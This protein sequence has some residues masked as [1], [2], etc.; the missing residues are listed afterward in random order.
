MHIG[1][2]DSS[3]SELQ[4]NT[5][6]DVDP[7]KH[8]SEPPRGSED[9]DGDV[10]DIK[11]DPMRLLKELEKENARLSRRNME[12]QAQ[13]AFH[14]RGTTPHEQDPEPDMKEYQECLE[15]LVELRRQRVSQMEK[16]QRQEEELRLINQE[17]L[18]RVEDEWQYLLTWK[19]KVAVS[20]LRGHLSPEAARAKVDA[21][22]GSEQRHR[23]ELRKLRLVHAGMESR[24]IRLEAELGEEEQEEGRD[25][26]LR[27]LKQLVAQRTLERKAN[28]RRSQEASKIRKN[29]KRTL[30]L[31]S[32][33]K[34]KLHWSHTE[35][36]AKREQLTRLEAT[37]TSR[38]DLLTR[39]KRAGGSLR[40]DNAELKRTRGLLGNTLLLWDFGVTVGASQRLQDKLEEL[41]GRREEIASL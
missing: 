40:R 21:A 15:H 27:Q 11:N 13:M 28:E 14:M 41:K 1:T 22:L 30:E 8:E 37:L 26:L 24:V 38:R 35:A 3:E 36:Q 18:N 29:I 34:E 16:A 20:L 5:E 6:G 31:L 7:L 12:L 4:E 9:L 33:I 25:L 23:Q 2:E 39:T 10:E 32:N 19:K 17:M